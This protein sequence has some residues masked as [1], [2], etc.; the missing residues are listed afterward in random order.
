SP[1]LDKRGRGRVMNAPARAETAT[2]T[3]CLGAA[4]TSRQ[5]ATCCPSVAGLGTG[6]AVAGRR[7]RPAQSGRYVVKLGQGRVREI[8]AAAF[9][10]SG[11]STTTRLTSRPSRRAQSLRKGNRE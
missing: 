7:D 2:A 5:A 6:D 3:D 4:G 1:S 9:A 11:V 8:M 10:S